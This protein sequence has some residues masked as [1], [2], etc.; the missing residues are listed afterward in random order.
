MERMVLAKSILVAAPARATS[1]RLERAIMKAI[2]CGKAEETM[3]L[4]M[5]VGF[6]LTFGNA[7]AWA[8]TEYNY[9]DQGVA[10]Q[11]PVKPQIQKSTYD[12]TFAK[13][14]PAMVYSAEDDHV[15]YRLMAGRFT[16]ISPHSR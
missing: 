10:I 15:Q 14:L 11:F 2:G 3:R 7:Q 6:A 1:L 12:T 8:W 5:A 16:E 4:I 13:G 9:P